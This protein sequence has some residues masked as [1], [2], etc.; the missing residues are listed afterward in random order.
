M[1]TLRRLLCAVFGHRCRAVFWPDLEP[2]GE[3]CSWCGLL[4]YCGCADC[5]ARLHA[6]KRMR[7]GR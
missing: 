7:C 1:T 3:Q 2:A 4:T 5:R 6:A